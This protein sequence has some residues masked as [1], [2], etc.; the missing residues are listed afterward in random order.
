MGG[1]PP[2]PLGFAPQGGPEAAL[3]GVPPGPPAETPRGSTPSRGG[4]GSPLDV[5]TLA[6]D[7]R[8]GTR[9]RGV[10]GDHD[11]PLGEEWHPGDPRTGMIL[12]GAACASLGSPPASPTGL[13][14]NT[15]AAVQKPRGGGG[16][17]KF[18]TPRVNA[19]VLRSALGLDNPGAGGGADPD[20]REGSDTTRGV[21]PPTRHPQGADRQRPSRPPP[22]GPGVPPGAVTSPAR[23]GMLT[24]DRG[25]PPAI[26]G[27]PTTSPGRRGVPPATPPTPRTPCRRAGVWTGGPPGHRGGPR[28]T[29]AC[30]FFWVF[31]N[32]PSRDKDGTLFGTEIWDKNR[33]GTARDKNRDGA[34]RWDRGV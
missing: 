12:A 14:V 29:P 1:A 4:G 7:P 30:T 21:G 17:E 8:P 11:E 5:G 18:R 31:N 24:G 9:R 25:Y 15:P 6:A 27:M 10:E 26:R 22:G 3:F 2:P 20:R 19:G 33:A 28:D 13:A 23:T 34:I 32:S 16:V